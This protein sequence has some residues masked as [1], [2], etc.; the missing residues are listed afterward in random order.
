MSTNFPVFSHPSF[1]SVRVFM[2]DGEPWFV[3]NDVAKALGYSVP[4][5]A[6]ATHCDYARLFKG[7][8]LPPLNNLNGLGIPPRGM[9]FIPESDVYALIFGSTLPAAKDFRT[10]VCEDV[11]PSIRKTGAYGYNLPAVPKS[12]P[13]ALRMIADIEEEKQLAVEQRDYYKRTKAQIGSRREATSMAKASAAVRKA[14]RLEDELGR[15]ET[16]REVKAIPWLYDVFRPSKGMYSVIGKTLKRLS[17]DLGYEVKKI[18]SP[19]YP[20]GVN[21]YHVDVLA[22]F[23]Q[24]LGR[25]PDMLGRY[26]APREVEA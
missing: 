5:D 21:A 14:A 19:E 15:G 4:K 12:F 18:P 1:G 24:E 25:K 22:S 13:D 16:Y 8:D 20:D 3:A 10:W 17:A 11:L 9:M 6:V 26:R 23:R 2:K 7:G